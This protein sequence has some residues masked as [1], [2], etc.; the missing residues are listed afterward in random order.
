[1]MRLAWLSVVVLVACG[2][3]EGTP[4]AEVAVEVTPEVETTEASDTTDTREAT[5]VEGETNVEVEVDAVEPMDTTEVE[6][7]VDTT[8]AG[9]LAEGHFAGERYP[10]GD[11]CN[12]CECAADGT[13]T[14]TQRNCAFDIGG[15]VYADKPHDYGDRFPATDGVNECV[16]AASG[17]ACTRRD[18]SLPEEGA[19][20]LES[21]DAPC[22]EDAT[23]TG[24][25]VLDGLPFPVLEADFKY[26]VSRELYPESRPPTTATV[27]LVRAA[28]DFVVCRIPDPSQPAIDMEVTVEFMTADGAFDEGFHTYLRRNNF[29]FVNAWYTVGGAPPGGLDGDYVAVCLDPNGYGFGMTWYAD[30]TYSG[31]ASKT[32]ETDIPLDVGIFGNAP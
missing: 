6:V 10:V 32:C 16:C 7:E 28:T 12:F 30:K 22:G 11:H 4:A 27:R 25:A 14:C 19:I 26:I 3:D 17:L 15:C 21:M 2:D 13:T 23:F 31:H 5:E 9:C 1:M 24:N 29:G 20:L 18:G 8:P